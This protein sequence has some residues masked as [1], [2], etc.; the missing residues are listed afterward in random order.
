MFS[1]ALPP[2]ILIMKRVFYF[3]RGI[4][5][6]G[7]LLPIGWFWS[8]VEN[9]KLWQLSNAAAIER[10]QGRFV[11]CSESLGNIVIYEVSDV[12]GWSKQ[13][14]DQ[15]CSLSQPLTVTHGK[16]HF[17]LYQTRKQDSAVDCSALLC[18]FFF[19]HSS[20]DIKYFVCNMIHVCF[21]LW[22]HVNGIFTSSLCTYQWRN[23][24]LRASYSMKL[25]E[26]L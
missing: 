1:D 18:L 3:A 15:L 19:D 20:V 6:H 16:T 9:V 7:D 8:A 2:V 5:T 10:F 14:M 13:I 26:K 22:K 24:K 12:K 17:I 25:F 23:K 11:S 21:W 4:A